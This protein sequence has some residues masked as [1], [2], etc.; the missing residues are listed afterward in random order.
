MDNVD[1]FKDLGVQFDNKLT[2]EGHIHEKIN[3][4]YSVL[5]IIKK[6]F[7][8][9]WQV[10]IHFVVYKAMVRSHIEYAHSVW[11]AFLKGNIENRESSNRATKLIISLKHLTS[12][13]LNQLKLPTLKY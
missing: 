12:K 2:F 3:K 10:Y 7:I 13:R 5:G 8:L 4:A 1:T 6:N 11:N 9:C